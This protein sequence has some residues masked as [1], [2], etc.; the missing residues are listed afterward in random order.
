MEGES[1][2][3][4]GIASMRDGSKQAQ[5]KVGREMEGPDFRTKGTIY[6]SKVNRS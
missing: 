1:A 3:D 2:A 5:M 6:E 4:V